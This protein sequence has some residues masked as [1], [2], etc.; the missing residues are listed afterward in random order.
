METFGT[1]NTLII[2]VSRKAYFLHACIINRGFSYSIAIDIVQI[3]GVRRKRYRK[4][5][6]LN[7]KCAGFGPL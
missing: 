4:T 3:K 1:L 7:E 2:K 6:P 5:I